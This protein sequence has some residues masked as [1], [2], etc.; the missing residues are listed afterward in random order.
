MRYGS[1][2]LLG[3]VVFFAG[4][5]VISSLVD[6]DGNASTVPHADD[7]KASSSRSLRSYTGGADEG[8]EGSE[9]RVGAGDVSLKLEKWVN[10]L[11][12]GT[13]ST[14]KAAI[15]TL[16]NSKVH[17]KDLFGT[18][19]LSASAAKLDDN[20][21][22]VQWFRLAAA[23]RRKNGEQ[24]LPDLEIYYILLRQHQAN[25]VT[26]L[27]QSL[28]K[29]PGLKKLATSMENS[30]S[31]SWINKNLKLET[32]PK[33]LFN[34]LRLKEAGVKLDETPVFHQWLKYVDS[35]RT[36]KGNHWFDDME[37]LN[38]FRKTMPEQNVVTLLH[39][40]RQT[41]RMTNR[42][43]EMQRFLFL[44]SQSSHQ[45]MLNVWLKAQERPEKVYNILRLANVDMN[46]F[47]NNAMIIQWLRYTK[48]FRDKAPSHSF[49]G[50]Q[51]VRF[52][53]KERP[54][55][56][57]WEFAT[58]FQVLKETPDLKRQAENMQ[59]YL[60]RQ[61]LGGD[62]DPKSV[63]SMLAIPHPV[64]VVLLPKNDPIH[65]TWEAFTLYFAKYKGGEAMLKKVKAAFANEN[66]RGALAATIKSR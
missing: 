57:D 43:D 20:P 7:I 29:T 15:K 19:R 21:E 65:L 48:L 22:L 59:T 64:N 25:E 42:A 28:K 5:T 11:F 49:S 17:P 39:L 9:E 58:L 35:Y 62:F 63:A 13:S 66:P 51:T 10:K 34:T 18:L 44:E 45:L 40:L 50:V 24:A 2:I 8:D 54:F 46:G 31:G 12:T 55:Q 33:A 60:F 47:D 27:I 52:L 26:S 4:I 56:S 61:W 3:I 53:K 14:E 1:G 30:L 41:P 37:M 32:D 16:L 38:L 23:Y 36:T 6:I